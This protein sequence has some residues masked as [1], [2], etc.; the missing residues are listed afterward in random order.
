MRRTPC[1]VSCALLLHPAPLLTTTLH[2]NLPLP[3]PRPDRPRSPCPFPSASHSA[4]PSIPAWATW[5]P[6]RRRQRLV[7][8]PLARFSAAPRA[9]RSG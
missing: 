2:P 7:K 1:P 3:I 5:T 4:L 9:A 6:E 8:P